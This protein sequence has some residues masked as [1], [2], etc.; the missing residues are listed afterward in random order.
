MQTFLIFAI[1]GFPEA[2][3][4][5]V[6]RKKAAAADF[7]LGA[8][9]QLA[10]ALSLIGLVMLFLG[11][12]IISSLADRALVDYLLPLFLAVVVLALAETL[13]VAQTAQKRFRTFSVIYI[14]FAVLQSGVVVTAAILTRQLRPV[15]WA[16]L[17][18]SAIKALTAL[19]WIVWEAAQTGWTARPRMLRQQW[20]YALPYTGVQ[21]LK[22]IN[23]QLHRYFVTSSFSPSA[24]AIYDIGTKQ[25]PALQ[26]LRQSVVQVMTPHFAEMEEQKRHKAILSL[27]H[28]SVCRLSL[29][30]YASAALLVAFAPDLMRL[31]FTSSYAGAAPIFRIF[32]FTML[33]DALG[34]IEA[35]LKAFAQ[36]RFILWTTALQLGIALVGSWAGLKWIGLLGPALAAVVAHTAGQW[37]RIGRIRQLMQVSTADLLPWR[38]LAST[39]AVASLAA[40][41]GHAAASLAQAPL[42]R[43]LLGLPV[44]AFVY[45]AGTFWLGLIPPQ[46]RERIAGWLRL[47]R[48]PGGA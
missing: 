29:V 44:F 25:V 32:V 38:T 14:G 35:L 11:R 12:A 15:I 43:L 1:A 13:F 7:L 31:L 28:A 41:L 2:L 16:F 27:W 5:F 18:G 40:L 48:I 4:Y 3:V 8:L 37:I 33:G 42:M 47:V 9:V 19:G 20:S 23:G 46:E 39:L 34:G 10:T 30:Y 36:N 6:S 45:L 22:K 24:Y 17:A 21:A 26:L